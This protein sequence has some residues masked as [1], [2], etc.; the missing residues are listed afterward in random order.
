M[1]DP[2]RCSRPGGSGAPRTCTATSS[3]GDLRAR[4]WRPPHR[5]VVVRRDSRQRRL[6]RGD[7][8]DLGVLDPGSLNEDFA[9]ESRAGDIFEVEMRGAAS[10]ASSEAQI[11][12]PDAQG[13]PPNLP[14]WLGEA[15]SDAS[16]SSQSACTACSDGW[17]GD[18]RRPAPP[19]PMAICPHPVPARARGAK[20]LIGTDAAQAA[21]STIS[22]H[23]EGADP[24]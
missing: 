10:C 13:Q 22:A 23:A 15:A 7:G 14:F 5:V 2:E 21:A 24:R 19:P 12:V 8:I 18:S 17:G 16:G 1:L 20:R 9:I 3:P 4:R 11:R 6:R